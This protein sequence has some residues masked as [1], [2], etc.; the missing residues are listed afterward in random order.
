M[1]LRS[2]CRV[3]NWPNFNIVVP[4]GAEK[5]DE[6]EKEGAALRNDWWDKKAPNLSNFHP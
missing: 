3:S 4:L 6:R 1:K 2:D 5:P